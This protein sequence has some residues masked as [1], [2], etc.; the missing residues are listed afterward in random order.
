LYL[1]VDKLHQIPVLF[2]LPLLFC[3]IA[4]LLVSDPWHPV[5]SCV[6]QVVPR[7]DL[8]ESFRLTLAMSDRVSC[9]GRCWS[10]GCCCL[11]LSHEELQ[12]V[13]LGFLGRLF[14]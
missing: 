5:L 6:K 7:N 10:E 11:K 2:D 9:R 12:A 8:Q 14:L 13:Q 4:S 3:N 1:G